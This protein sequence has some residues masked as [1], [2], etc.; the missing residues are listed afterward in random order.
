[1]NYLSGMILIR[2][3]ARMKKYDDVNLVLD[4]LSRTGNVF[5]SFK[6]R[7]LMIESNGL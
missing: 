6:G 7:M 1:M 5:F 2:L 3:T 4:M